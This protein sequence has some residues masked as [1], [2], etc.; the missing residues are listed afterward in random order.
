MAGF[1]I[2]EWSARKTETKAYIQT[3]EVVPEFRR[4]G[5]GRELLNRAEESARLAGAASIWL[6]VDA[7]N[8]GAILLYETQGYSC[9]GRKED[10]YPLGRAGLIYMKRLT[11][12]SRLTTASHELEHGGRAR[13]SV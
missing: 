7:E 12:D 11:A 13:N 10:F 4:R 1:A 2:V 8:A 3:I 9:Q 5:V 6:H